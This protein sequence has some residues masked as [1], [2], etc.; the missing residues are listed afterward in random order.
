MLYKTM[1]LELLQQNSTLHEQLRRSRQLMPTLD[2]C[3][4][5][6]KTAHEALIAQLSQTRPACDPS[7]IA[8]EALELALQEL[9]AVLPTESPES[10]DGA[11]FPPDEAM[12]SVCRRTPPA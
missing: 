4:L 12:A 6:L 11:T 7:Q 10:E 2:R 8:S 3:S 1:V 9:R 5:Q